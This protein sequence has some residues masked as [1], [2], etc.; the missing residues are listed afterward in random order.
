[1]RTTK[2]KVKND[3]KRISA[4]LLLRVLGVIR[5]IRSAD[6]SG[7][8]AHAIIFAPYT[9]LKKILVLLKSLIYEIKEGFAQ[10]FYVIWH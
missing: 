10:F 1:M 5:T 3:L 9:L 4:F 6:E 8:V 2:R 7:K